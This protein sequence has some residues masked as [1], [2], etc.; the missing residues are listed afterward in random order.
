[1]TQFGFLYVLQPRRPYEPTPQRII[2]ALENAVERAPP[3]AF[4]HAPK[5]HAQ[6]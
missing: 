3:R 2:I 5:I 4:A 1:M 6:H